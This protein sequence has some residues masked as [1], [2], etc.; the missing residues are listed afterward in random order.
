MVQ[1]TQRDLGIAA[2]DDLVGAAQNG[3]IDWHELD[4]PVCDVFIQLAPRNPTAFLVNFAFALLAEQH[5][6]RASWELQISV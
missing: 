5:S 1:G 4:R 6:V 2:F 3:P